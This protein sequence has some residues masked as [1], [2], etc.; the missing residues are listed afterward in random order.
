MKTLKTVLIATIL[1]VG[2]LSL[3]SAQ[4][5]F[6]VSVNTPGVHI[7]AGNYHRG[8][9]GPAYYAPAPAYYA[10]AYPVYYHHYYRPAYYRHEYRRAYYRHEYYRPAYHRVYRHW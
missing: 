8:Y 9:Y 7:S 2:S 6:H 5:R 1:T 4:T 10:P 3:A